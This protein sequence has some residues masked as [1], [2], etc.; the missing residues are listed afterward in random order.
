MSLKKDSIYEF[1]A[2]DWIPHLAQK[3]GS[4]QKYAWLG[5]LVSKQQCE[6][7]SVQS[8]MKFGQ[9]LISMKWNLLTYTKGFAFVLR[10]N[11]H[12]KDIVINATL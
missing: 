11:Q 12:G 9:Y 8:R 3:F 5:K 4:Q 10:F 2:N 7:C 1:V 6:M